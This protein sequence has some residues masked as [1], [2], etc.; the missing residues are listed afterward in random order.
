MNP[1]PVNVLFLCTHNS[2]RS[3]LA[4]AMVNHYGKGR[5]R[6]FSAGSQ[7]RGAVHPL[8]LTVLS[9]SGISVAGLRSKSWDEFASR[10]APRMDLVITVCDDAAG[11]ICP[12]WPGLPATAHWGYADPSAVVGNEEQRL[13]AFRQTMLQMRRRIELLINLPPSALGRMALQEEARRLG[14]A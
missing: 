10:D 1:P 12:L 11:E 5:F 9:E 6:G 13:A 7:P 14:K 3:V 4:E 8:S 2:A